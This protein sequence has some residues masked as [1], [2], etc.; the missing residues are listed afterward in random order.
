MKIT[1]FGATGRTGSRLVKKALRDKHEVTIVT[2]QIAKVCFDPAELRIVE[3]NVLTPEIVQTAVEGADVIISCL[4]AD[5][6]SKPFKMISEGM[7]NIVEA[8][9]EAG[10][11]RIVSMSGS[12]IL[13]HPEA[14]YRGRIDFP[15]FLQFSFEDNLR[16]YKIIR[17]TDLDWTIVCPTN[18]PEGPSI[19]TYRIAIDELPD[20]PK[21]VSVGDV[22]GLIYKIATENLHIRS[23][24]G[25]A[26]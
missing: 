19:G 18:M 14:K 6:I 3:G 15:P 13:T 5:D 10:V 11:K 25:I 1:I 20:E 23:R 4:G 2:R 22:A 21:P 9:K 12:G 16:A 8:M 17:A 26:N 7:K 24:V